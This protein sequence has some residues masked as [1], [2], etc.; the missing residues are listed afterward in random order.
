[1]TSRIITVLAILCNISHVLAQ[2]TASEKA[3]WEQ[4]QAYWRYVKSGDQTG[5][6]TIWA[7]DF[8]GWPS[9]E[10]KPVDVSKISVWKIND[11]K[12]TP[13]SVREHS[14]DLVITF[15]HATTTDENGKQHTGRLT[16]TWKRI[17][18]NWKII[19]GMACDEPETAE[20]QPVH[21]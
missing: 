1:M 12:L 8:S 5:F 16:H 3:A 17:D 6:R 13:L 10:P 21:H 20:S 18:G 4:E 2:Q 9:S 19:G 7:D 11:Y 15:Y 14:P